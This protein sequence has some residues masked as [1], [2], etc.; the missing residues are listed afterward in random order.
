MEKPIENFV[1]RS[2][3]G[4]FVGRFA[5]RPEDPSRSTKA[6]KGRLPVVPDKRAPPLLILLAV[7]L[8]VKGL[9]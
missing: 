6:G 3:I 9:P 1:G 5:V 2:A 8:G 4:R 7:T